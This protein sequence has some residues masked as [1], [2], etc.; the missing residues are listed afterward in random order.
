M[1]TETRQA[2]LV[3]VPED[4]SAEA[5]RDFLQELSNVIETRPPTVGVDCSRLAQVTSSHVNLLWQAHR[6]CE[7]AGGALQLHA[8]SQNLIRILRLLDLDGMFSFDDSS[9]PQ[10][11]ESDVAVTTEGIDIGL[12]QFIQ[13]LTSIGVP[14]TAVFELRTILYEVLTNI[15]LHSGL[16]TGERVQVTAVQEDASLTLTF[17]DA[18]PPFD[19]TARPDQ[20]DFRSAAREG[21]TR[22]FG[23]VMIKRLASSVGYVRSGNHTNVLTVTKDWGK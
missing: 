3:T 13:F 1:P 20:L 4:L 11:F 21:Q 18:G 16:P 22:G 7:S 8:A 14:E 17:V 5:V 2:S 6:R 9:L 15:R 10:S 19:P 23:I 12:Q